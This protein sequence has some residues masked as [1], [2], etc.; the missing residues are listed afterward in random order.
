MKNIYYFSELIFLGV[1]LSRI[2]KIASW[3]MVET[4]NLG[5]R[6]LKFSFADHINPKRDRLQNVNFHPLAVVSRYRD[7]QLQV[8]EN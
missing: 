6:A 2:C 3:L 5:I 8:V 7:P 1:S 4:N